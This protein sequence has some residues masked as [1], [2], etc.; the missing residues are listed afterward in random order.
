MKIVLIVVLA[1]VPFQ[2]FAFGR[3][4]HQKVVKMA[5]RKMT[6]TTKTQVDAL[7]NSKPDGALFRSCP[8]G[9]RDNMA[10]WLD[11]ES[12][13]EVNHPVWGAIA[14]SEGINLC[15][16][17][18]ALPAGCGSVNSNC[19]GDV[20]TNSMNILK[21]TTGITNER[22][23]NLGVILHLVG[24]I[25][26][27]MHAGNPYGHRVDID[28]SYHSPNTLHGIWD[29]EL[30]KDTFAEYSD[31]DIAAMMDAN[32][33]RWMK[34]LPNE[35]LEVISHASRDEVFKPLGLYTCPPVEPTTQIPITSAYI[36]NAKDVELKQIAKAADRLAHILNKAFDPSY[37]N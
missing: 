32:S 12:S 29:S 31:S 27:P 9:T 19:P 37:P 16:A 24:D 5:Y 17:Q 11:C 21:T 14:H 25:H 33:A 2:A 15:D 8:A 18:F 4:G 13:P 10:I 26:Q 30:V 22:L 3:A 34:G 23:A 7:I 35:W 1:L 6:A 36:E 20:I 28:V